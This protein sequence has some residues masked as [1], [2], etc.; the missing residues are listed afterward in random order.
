MNP[1]ALTVL[2]FH[3]VL[4]RVSASALSPLG[5]ERIR[6]L[7]PGGHPSGVQE[8]LSRV[9]EMAAFLGE[10]RDWVPPEIPD[11][12]DALSRLS[13]EGAVLEPAELYALGSLLAGGGDLDEGL[14]KVREELPGLGFLRDGLYKDRGLE[15]AIRKVVDAEG[16]ILD[17]ASKE[18]GRLS[19]NGS[20]WRMPPSPSGKVGTSFRS[21]E[22]ERGKWPDRF[23]TSQRRARPSSW[24]LPLP[25]SS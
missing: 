15:K 16:T 18:L 19:R 21:G 25:S 22:K 14:A 13:L 24:S 8:E 12:R 5:R 20:S 6:T 10:H 7:R 1:H 23:W 9:E 4:E 17:T 11:A 2:E 3:E